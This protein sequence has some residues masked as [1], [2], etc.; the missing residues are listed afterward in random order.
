MP[1]D[2]QVGGPQGL[3]TAKIMCC[4]LLVLAAV[5]APALGGSSRHPINYF[6]G[7]SRFSTPTK[8]I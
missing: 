1:A 7:G 8:V 6:S 2:L 4:K 3:F 5:G